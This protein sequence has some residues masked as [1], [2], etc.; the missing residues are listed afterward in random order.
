MAAMK[1]RTGRIIIYILIILIALAFLAYLLLSRN[2]NG[3]FGQAAPTATPSYELVQ[4]VV[5]SQSIPRGQVISADLLST[6]QY[7]KKD[8]VAGTFFTS[9]SDA[10]GSKAKYNIDPGVPLTTSMVLHEGSGSL[11]AN[12]IPTGMTAYSL[13][14]SPETAVAYAPQSGDHVMVMACMLLLDVDTS[15]QTRLA[16]NTTAVIRAGYGTIESGVHEAMAIAPYSAGVGSSR[17]RFELDSTTNE[18][19][20]VVPSEDQR[21]RLVCQTVLQDVTV[22]KVGMFPLESEDKAVVENPEVPVVATETPA[23]TGPSYPGSVT[24]IV[25]PQDNLI[26]NYLSLAG[27]KLSLALR[28]AV[29][30]AVYTTDPV[31][32]QYIMDTKNIPAPAKLPYGTEPRVDSLIYPSFNDYI[33]NQP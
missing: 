27:A 1:K 22:L 13:A 6:I 29:D 4:I 3:G 14:T 19:V 12:D 24:L 8:L 21:P 25:S 5:A 31:T 15:Y 17:G 11:A 7:P 2:N 20:Y 26:L 16:N 28:S 33:L 23:E 30:T 10:I 18:P 32:L 9:T